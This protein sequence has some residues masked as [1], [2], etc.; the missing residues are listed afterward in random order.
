[1]FN[2]SREQV[3]QFFFDSW[4]KHKSGA[5]LSGMEARAV[6][7]MLMHPEYHHFLDQPERSANLEFTP[8]SGNI[9]P[10]LHMSLH[11]ALAEQFALDQPKGMR[12]ELQRLMQ[13][14]ADVHEALHVALECL[15]QAMWESQR[16]GLEPDGNAYLESLRRS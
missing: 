7:I 11:L 14:K 1:M 2:P 8:E 9:N 4:G 5:L 13:Q 15:G 3:R 12:A 10:F 16:N 6:D